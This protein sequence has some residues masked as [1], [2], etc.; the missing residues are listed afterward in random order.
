M[1]ATK[2]DKSKIIICF[3]KEVIFISILNY[4]SR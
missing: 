3:E 4:Y 1:I 2:S